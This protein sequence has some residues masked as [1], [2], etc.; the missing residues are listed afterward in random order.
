MDRGQPCGRLRQLLTPRP[1]PPAAPSS[2]EIYP[3]VAVDPWMERK[4]PSAR[5]PKAKAALLRGEHES[6]AGFSEDEKAILLELLQ[7]VV[8]NIEGKDPDEGA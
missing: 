4:W 2:T 6:M 5:I 7:R 8:R 1:A 3:A